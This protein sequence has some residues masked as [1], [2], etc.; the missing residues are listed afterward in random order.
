MKEAKMVVVCVMS[1]GENELCIQGFGWEIGR[2]DSNDLC[3]L[4][5][6][7]HELDSSGSAQFTDKWRTVVK[8]VF[9]NR[10]NFLIIS[11][12]SNTAT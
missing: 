1:T 11:L 9:I 2:K 5:I 4:E 3:R 10:G 12:S 8:A 7:E 6:G